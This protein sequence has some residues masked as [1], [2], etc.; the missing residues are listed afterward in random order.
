M[1]IFTT[2]LS[3]LFIWN[4]HLAQTPDRMSY[5]AIIRDQNHQLVTNQ[6]IGMRINILHGSATGTVVY[7]EV[8]TP[9]TNANGLVSIE[10]GGGIGFDTINWANGPYYIQ[11]ETDLTGGNNYTI[12]GTQQFLSVPYALYAETGGTP[13]PAGPQGVQG[14]QGLQGQPGTSNCGTINSGDGRIVLYN[15]TNAWGYGYNDTYG[16]FFYSI[17]LSGTL[18]GA[19]A[20]DSSIVIYTSTHAYGFG[21]NNT[22]GSGW[23]TKA[24]TAPPVGYMVTNGRIVLYNDTEAYG[25]GRNN[26]SGSGWYTRVLSAPVLGSFASGNRILLYNATEAYGFGYNMTSGSDWKLQVLP[27]PPIDVTGT[28]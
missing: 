17:S 16:S 20:S 25:F 7:E 19:L 22:S 3:L 10:V 6:I 13:G 26:T 12:S 23:Y 15:A 1:K 4:V 18:L 27:A 2:F 21:K 8:Q 9:V 24:I 14:P 11:T 5:Q 28:R